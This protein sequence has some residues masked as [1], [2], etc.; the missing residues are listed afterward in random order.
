MDFIIDKTG[1]IN[2][3]L[4]N[5]NLGKASK[6]RVQITKTTHVSLFSLPNQPNRTDVAF[7][8]LLISAGLDKGQR[9]GLVGWKN[10]TSILEDNKHTYDVPYYI[11]KNIIDIIGDEA[12]L[13]NECSI[14]IGE[15][16]ARCTNN[17][18]EIAHYEYG[19]ALASDCILDAMNS[20]NLN[21]N[22]LELG[23]K[24]VRNGQH[25]SIVTIASSGP[26]FIKA[27]MFSRDNTVKLGDPISLTVGYR[28][29]SS[30][31]CG[32]AVENE[33]QLPEGQKDYLERIAIPYFN[34]Y[35]AW[36]EN[37]KCGLQGHKIFD[38]IENELP[39]EKYGWSLC[40]GH[41][42]A[43]EEWMSSPICQLPI[44]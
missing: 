16:G 10:F 18:N 3:V 31:R 44:S 7:K 43:E 30:S 40:P 34:A 1:E 42:T 32:L 24:L 36:L 41:L 35:V 14:F 28:G 19:A 6:S 2:I 17:P 25:T 23:D 20:L 26:R 8:D 9:I 37:I 38:L 27:N 15:D 13:S 21:T 22:E 11:V 12:L 39:R 4:G 5:E 33:T 29:G